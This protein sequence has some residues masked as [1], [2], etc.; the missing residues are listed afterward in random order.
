MGI[1][2]R[3]TFVKLGALAGVGLAGTAN[4]QDTT[5]T[6]MAGDVV[7]YVAPLS[8]ENQVPPVE[9]DATGFALFA[10][11]EESVDY[12]LAVAN[13]ENMLMGHI[14]MAGPDENGPIV[15]W[16][17]PSV[18][19]REPELREGETNGI[20]A[21]GTFT[22]E[23]FVGPLEGESLDALLE[24]MRTS[25]VYVN[26]HTQQHKPGEIRGQVRPAGELADELS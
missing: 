13:N 17:D 4:A 7:L 14:H 25:E 6:Q 16:L 12:A 3:R 10:V 2:N 22:A 9:T 19:A 18:D 15:V 8:G 26:V 5:T 24:R 11:G 20:T 23:D 1:V 21:T